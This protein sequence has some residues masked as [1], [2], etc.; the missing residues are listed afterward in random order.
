M[1]GFFF[2]L[3][4]KSNYFRRGSIG[5]ENFGRRLRDRGDRAFAP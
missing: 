1:A 2:V 4:E 3:Q 5:I